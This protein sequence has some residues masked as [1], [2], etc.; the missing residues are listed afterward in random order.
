MFEAVE[1]YKEWQTDHIFPLSKGWEDNM[2]NYALS[3]RICNLL[4]VHGIYLNI[5][6]SS[7]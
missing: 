5:L 1:N 7:R 3:C 2:K 6:E 4:K